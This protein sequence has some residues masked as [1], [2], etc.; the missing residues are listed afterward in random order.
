MNTAFTYSEVRSLLQTNSIK[1]MYSYS[2][3]SNYV[4]N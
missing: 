1:H 3:L 4:F 2:N